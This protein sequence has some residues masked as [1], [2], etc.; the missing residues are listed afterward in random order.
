MTTMKSFA[1]VKLR[2]KRREFFGCSRLFVFSFVINISKSIFITRFVVANENK[3]KR[4]FDG[5]RGREREREQQL[6]A[7]SVVARKQPLLH[8]FPRKSSIFF[9][10]TQMKT[11]EKRFENVH[12]QLCTHTQ[13]KI[14]NNK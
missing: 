7:R 10:N 9:S 4:D 3:N 11:I 1:V 8:S 13:K 2:L 12:T 6:R 14:H 5:E